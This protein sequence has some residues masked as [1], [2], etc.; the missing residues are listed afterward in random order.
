LVSLLPYLNY[1]ELS[2]I[3]N[4]VSPEELYPDHWERN[5]MYH[6]FILG[7][8]LGLEVHVVYFKMA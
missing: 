7:A 6:I 8:D 1:R 5:N 3:S 4:S 2:E